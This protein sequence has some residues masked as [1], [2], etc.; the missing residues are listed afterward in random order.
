M[1]SFF[2]RLKT[3]FEKRIFSTVHSKQKGKYTN[4]EQY[5]ELLSGSEM[6]TKYGVHNCI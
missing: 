3:F 4:R 2:Y 6:Y 5:I 1:I